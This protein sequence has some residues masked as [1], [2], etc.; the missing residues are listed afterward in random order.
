VAISP[1]STTSSTVVLSF[2]S[3]PAVD[4]VPLL[5]T[6]SPVSLL[7]P[8]FSCSPSRLL[9]RPG[10]GVALGVGVGAVLGRRVTHPTP[11][12]VGQ[13]A[14]ARAKFGILSCRGTLDDGSISTVASDVK[15][16]CDIL[17]SNLKYLPKYSSQI[18]A[19]I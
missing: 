6:D 5:M 19:T 4:F 2:P 18:I 1:T 17:F 12:P 16:Y 9:L 8:L 11:L 3:T 10:G 14:D 7:L 15:L 13:C